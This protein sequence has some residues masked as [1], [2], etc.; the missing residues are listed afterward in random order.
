M[1]A[2]WEWLAQ[3]KISGPKCGGQEWTG[4]L[5]DTAEHAMGVS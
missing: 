5:T 3:N 4:Q 1:K 2:T